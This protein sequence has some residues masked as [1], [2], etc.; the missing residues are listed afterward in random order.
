MSRVSRQLLTPATLGVLAFLVVAALYALIGRNPILGDILVYTLIWS[1]IA[2]AWNL[3]G[4][5][6]GRLSL[7]HA[8]YFGIGAYASSILYLKFGITPWLGALVGM[9]AAAAVGAL[10]E[11]T[12][13][14]LVGIYYGLAT[15]AI[16]EVLALLARGWRE[17]TGGMAGL[18][19]PFRPS[20]ANMTYIGKL[21]YIWTALAFA[22]LC[23]GITAVIMTS[24]FGF[25]LRAQRDE[26]VAARALGVATSRVCLAAGT[27]SAALTALGGTIYAQYL[28]FIDPDVGF[29]WYISVQAA[30]LCLIGG[31]GTLAG[32]VWGAMLLIP[33]ER[34]LQGLLGSSYGGLAPAMY[35]LLLMVVVL[36]MPKGLAWRLSA[37]RARRDTSSKGTSGA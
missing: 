9:A 29:N 11:A 34:W 33:L 6:A 32:P 4:G 14:R 3:T 24:R 8:A 18:T 22:A 2:S 10:I 35:G 28:L 31:L 16:A 27:I 1:G 12:T 5:F 25:Y 23:L 37:A 13:V 30:L 7:G 17:L 21:G 36:V 15:F 20:I 19:L 26:P